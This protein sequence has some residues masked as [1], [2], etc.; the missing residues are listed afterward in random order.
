[1]D[2]FSLGLKPLFSSAC[3]QGW[4]TA[5]GCQPLG[6][7]PSAGKTHFTQNHS[8]FLGTAHIQRMV[9]GGTY[10][11]SPYFS[12]WKCEINLLG[13]PCFRA[14]SGIG[15]LL[16]LSTVIHPLL[17]PNFA[18]L[19]LPQMFY[20]SKALLLH[21]W[22]TKTLHTFQKHS[23]VNFL[24]ANFHLRVWFLGNW[25]CNALTMSEGQI[26]LFYF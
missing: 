3:E 9:H 2:A 24:R 6:W 11:L 15:G 16:C 10:R 7:L 1:M 20:F 4:L 12:V 14:S 25:T 26:L 18:S 21:K 13:H 22:C 23:M 19:I 8:L 5:S 17:L